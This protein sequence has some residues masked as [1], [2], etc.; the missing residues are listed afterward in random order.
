MQVGVAVGVAEG[1]PV[2]VGVN[3][4]VGE[5]VPHG[6]NNS[7]S[8]IHCPVVSPGG[9]NPSWCTRNLMRTVWPTYGVMSTSTLVQSAVSH[10]W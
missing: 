10:R 7:T 8:S 1:V 5:G 3:V 9:L 2:D 4:G 6:P